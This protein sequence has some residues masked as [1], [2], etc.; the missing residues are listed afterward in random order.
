MNN[1]LGF[2]TLQ[3]TIRKPATLQRLLV[4]INTVYFGIVPQ[5]A[6]L[7]NPPL[8]IPGPQVETYYLYSASTLS[9]GLICSL[10]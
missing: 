3:I 2:H 10:C 4:G 6:V 8:D 7:Y 9:P 5:P 1:L